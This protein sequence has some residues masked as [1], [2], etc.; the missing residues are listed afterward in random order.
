M[1]MYRRVSEKKETCSLG[2]EHIVGI[3]SV[4]EWTPTGETFDHDFGYGVAK[5]QIYRD[6]WGLT[7]RSFPT[8]DYPT[9]KRDE[10]REFWY[11]RPRKAYNET[12]SKT[13]DGERIS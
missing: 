2:C 5:G 6:Q 9:Y 11:T 13:L 3:Y 7:C 4:T 8:V 12:V 10:D 1:K